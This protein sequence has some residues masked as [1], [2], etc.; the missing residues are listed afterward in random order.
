MSTA[1]QP[2]LVEIGTEEVP[3]GALPGLAQALF[4]GVVDGLGKRG[5][6]FERGDAK[7]LHT[8]RRLAVLLPGVALKQ[9]EQHS[10]VLGPYV[11][12][13]LDADGQPTRALQGFAAKAGVEWTALE[14]T[15]DNKGER[16]VHRATTPGVATSALL[17][18]IVREVEAAA[19]G[20]IDQYVRTTQ[21]IDVVVG[22]TD[23]DRSVVHE[24]VAAAHAVRRKSEQLAVDDLVAVQ[25]HQPV[26]R[27]GEA[28][29][30]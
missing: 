3:V 23:P 30:A 9:P 17:P 20:R 21:G 1:M 29:I 15:S 6:A 28:R 18:E 26:H 16:F 27:P 8:P 12:I 24:A 19:L 14:R 4:D 11:N 10:E 22:R 13:A 5:I 25:Q 7:P 2:L